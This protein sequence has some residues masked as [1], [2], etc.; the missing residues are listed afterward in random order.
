MKAIEGQPSFKILICLIQVWSNEDMSKAL[1]VPSST[2]MITEAEDIEIVESYTKLIGTASVKFPRGTVI[3]KTVTTENIEEVAKATKVTANVDNGVVQ[4]LRTDSKI[5]DPSD[6][7][8]GSR[9]RISLGYTTDPKIAALPKLSADGTSIYNNTDKLNQYKS[10]LTVMFDGYIVKCS[11]ANPIELRCENLASG[12]KK[13]SCPKYTPGK[14][15][16]VNDFLSE[17]GDLKSLSKSGL[18][19]QPQT[20]RLSISLDK[21]PLTTDLTVADILTNWNKYK[22]YSYVKNDGTTPCIAVGRTYFSDLEKDSVMS[23]S[24]PV[25]I[26][27]SYHVASDDL[28]L[29]DTDK[30]FLAVEATSYTGS[31]FH[32]ITIRKNPDYKP[33]EPSSKKWQVMNETTLSKKAQK[34]GAISLTGSMERIDLSTY[35]IIPFMSRTIG[36]SNDDLLTEAIKYFEDYN[37]NGIE[38]TLTLFGDLELRT[39]QKVEL[40]DERYPQRN[41]YYLVEEVATTFGTKGY[42]QK[43]KIPYLIASKKD[44]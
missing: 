29:M 13:I 39:G 19:L 16:T 2:L 30:N 11:K 35:T 32:K 14:T 22:L 7:Q 6:F 42:R 17:K 4:T 5:A 23:T 1:E 37:M 8:I 18:K 21:K 27:F 38:G 3:K 25:K 43:I 24:S 34:A 26:L 28:T 31:K 41:G 15:M 12:L 36:I 9:I 20:E 44:E 40:V 10:A 33:D